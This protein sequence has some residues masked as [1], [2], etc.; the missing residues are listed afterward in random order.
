MENQCANIEKTAIN[1]TSFN[2]LITNFAD[3]ATFRF[4]NSIL[5]SPP[6]YRSQW[7]RLLD[8][9]KTIKKEHLGV[10]KYKHDYT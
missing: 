5:A 1:I 9:I 2:E 3:F 8:R 6:K 4:Q 10:G 7:Q